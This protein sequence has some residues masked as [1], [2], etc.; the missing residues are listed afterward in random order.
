MWTGLSWR[1]CNG[2]QKIKGGDNLKRNDGEDFVSYRARRKNSS[3][4]LRKYLRGSVIWNIGTYRKKYGKIG[5]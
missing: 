4:E 2:S 1:L 3:K 5:H